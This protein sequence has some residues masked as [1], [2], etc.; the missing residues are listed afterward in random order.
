M[1]SRLAYLVQNGRQKEALQEAKSYVANQTDGAVNQWMGGQ[2][3]ADKH[4]GIQFAIRDISFQSGDGAV[5]RILARA[6]N[7]NPRFL[8]ADY[9]NAAANK[10]PQGFLSAIRQARADYVNIVQ[11]GSGGR[12]DLHRGVLNRVARAHEIASSL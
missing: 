7:F 10:D 4:L 3:N 1:A 9:V 11:F 5:K 8:T 6:L 12:E 2:E